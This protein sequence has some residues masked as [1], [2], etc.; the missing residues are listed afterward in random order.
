[1][2]VKND[3]Q[4]GSAFRLRVPFKAASLVTGRKLHAGV[5]RFFGFRI[6][7]IGRLPESIRDRELERNQTL[8]ECSRTCPKTVEN[9][10]KPNGPSGKQYLSGIPP[11]A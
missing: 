9:P 5:P 11:F 7:S 10:H 2:R 3:P 8:D 1:M 4:K 6:S